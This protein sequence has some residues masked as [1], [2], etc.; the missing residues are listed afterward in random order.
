MD[1]PL[2]REGPGRRRAAPG[3]AL[4]QSPHASA[5]GSLG[6][7]ARDQLRAGSTRARMVVGIDGWVSSESIPMNRT[8]ARAR[9]GQV[10]DDRG[11]RLSHFGGF[12]GMNPYG[13]SGGEGFPATLRNLPVEA[14]LSWNS[15]GSSS[16]AWGSSLPMLRLQWVGE[17]APFLL[18]L[19]TRWDESPPKGASRGPICRLRVGC[20]TY[21]SASCT[22]PPVFRQDGAIRR[23]GRTP[24][25]T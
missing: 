15:S 11:L 21:P 22:S 1:L 12:A 19:E 16:W 7:C 20:G 10:S 17:S 18:S 9:V 25:S 5:S 14:L 2:H 3:R 13:E 4:S 6:H 8:N 24:P 23:R